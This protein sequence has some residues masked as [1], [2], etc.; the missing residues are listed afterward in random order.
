MGLLQTWYNRSNLSTT[1]QATVQNRCFCVDK[2]KE[3]GCGCQIHVQLSYFLGALLMWRNVEQSKRPG[4]PECECTCICCRDDHKIGRSQLAD[5]T[6][7]ANAVHH[8]EHC[9]KRGDKNCR[10]LRYVLLLLC[11]TTFIDINTHC[12]WYHI[13]CHS[14]MHTLCGTTLIVI[15]PCTLFVVPHSLSFIHCGTTLIVIHPCT[16]FVVPHSLT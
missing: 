14:S 1:V 2:H 8:S 6:A 11:G 3:R 7:F 15:H 9:V 4:R 12:L 10:P 13:R 16:L 5:C